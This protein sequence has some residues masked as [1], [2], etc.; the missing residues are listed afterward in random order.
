MK[1]RLIAASTAVILTGLVVPTA[2]HAGFAAEIKA[3]NKVE[4]RVEKRYRGYNI[5]ATCDQETK[6][7]FYCSF[8]GSKGDC[9]VTGKAW[10]KRGRASIISANKNCF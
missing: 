8:I 2:G 4:Q 5:T 10:V 9:Y 6:T 7:R 1:T 3:A